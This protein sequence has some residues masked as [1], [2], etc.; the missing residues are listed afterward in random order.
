MN[1]NDPVAK[2]ARTVTN[3]LLLAGL[4]TTVLGVV[5]LFRLVF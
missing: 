2:I 5:A 1:E 4:A 3:T